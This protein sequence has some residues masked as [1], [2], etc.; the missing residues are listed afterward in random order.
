MG[1]WISWSTTLAGLYRPGHLND[2]DWKHLQETLRRRN[3]DASRPLAAFNP[4]AEAPMNFT[5]R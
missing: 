1:A 3:H 2:V 5:A 4:Q